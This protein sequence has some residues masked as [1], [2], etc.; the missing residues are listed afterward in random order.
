MCVHAHTSDSS[1]QFEKLNTKSQALSFGVYV[2]IL[3]IKTLSDSRSSGHISSNCF[4]WNSEND[5]AI[6]MWYL[7]HL[8]DSVNLDGIYSQRTKKQFYTESY[9]IYNGF[10]L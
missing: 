3:K 1:G 7:S 5:S 2:V 4:S 8:D 6:H 9:V 10:V